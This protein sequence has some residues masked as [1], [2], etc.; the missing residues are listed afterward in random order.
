[1]SCGQE[2]N[3][4]GSLESQGTGQEVP[5]GCILVVCL[6]LSGL[7]TQFTKEKTDQSLTGR[8]APGVTVTATQGVPR[9]SSPVARPCRQEWTSGGK[10][11]FKV[12]YNLDCLEMECRAQRILILSSNSSSAS[13]SSF[14]DLGSMVRDCGDSVPPL[15]QTR[16]TRSALLIRLFLS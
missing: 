14:G 3:I 5:V 2:A 10:G 8:W 13:W 6:L 9:R 7:A 11:G 12:S 15:T 16:S 1:M 4:T